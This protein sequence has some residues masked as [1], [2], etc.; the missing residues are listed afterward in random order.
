MAR[1]TRKELKSDKFALEVEHTVSFFEEHRKEIVR[2]GAIAIA[3]AALVLGY[4]TYS[5][6]Q[7]TGREQALSHAIELERAPVGPA[8]PRG[9]PSFPTEAA[10]DQALIQA[11]SGI[12]ARYSGTTE[13]EIAQ[14]YLGTVQ[15]DQGKLVEAERAFQEVARNGRADYASLAKLAL[16]QVYFAQGK[17]RDGEAVLRDLM[18]HPTVFVSKEQAAV[19]LA[20]DLMTKNPAEA[21]KLLDPL[22]TQGGPVGQLVQ[23]LWSQ[24]PPQ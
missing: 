13:G 17:D 19:T 7:R 15:A 12:V 18:A 14:Y 22:K 9:G 6:H 3:V 20:Q 8:D 23:T 4:L 21:R 5:R 10:K 11:F 1:I 2:Y 24:L 16:G